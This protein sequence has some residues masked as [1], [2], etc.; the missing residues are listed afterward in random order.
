MPIWGKSGISLPSN[1]NL[2]CLSDK[3]V[4]MEWICWATTD[5]TSI[6][7]RL[8]LVQGKSFISDLNIWPTHQNIPMCH[9]AKKQFEIYLSY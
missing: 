6:L 9:S 2:F 1:T 5:K 3:A 8:N 4:K 7:I